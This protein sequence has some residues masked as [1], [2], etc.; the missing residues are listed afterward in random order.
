MCLHHYSDAIRKYICIFIFI[1]AMLVFVVSIVFIH[2]VRHR[3]TLTIHR[4]FKFQPACGG[5]TSWSGWSRA[6]GS[7]EGNRL[8]D[9]I[10]DIKGHK[11]ISRSLIVYRSIHRN[12][13]KLDRRISWNHF[14]IGFLNRHDIFRRRSNTETHVVAVL[15]FSPIFLLSQ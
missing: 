1:Q 9:S 12:V 10:S 7:P 8:L 5:Q 6:P 13:E 15:I 11:P 14:R 2:R 4:Y 3:R